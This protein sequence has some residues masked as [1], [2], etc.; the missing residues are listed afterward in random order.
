MGVIWAG[1]EDIQFQNGTPPGVDTTSGRFRAAFS[2]C[3]LSRTSTGGGASKGTQFPGGAV[4]TA[5]VTWYVS[6]AGFDTAN[7]N[8]ASIG[9][10]GQFSSSKG[11]VLGNAANG[12]LQLALYKYDGTTY[13]KLATESGAS[14]NF[15]GR[16]DMLILNYGATATVTVY[17]NQSPIPVITFTG[18]VTVSGM[19]NFDCFIWGPNLA[20]SGTSSTISEVIV[21]T[22]DTRAYLGLQ[23]LA[24]TG[25]GTTHT[26]TNNTFSNINGTAF[27]DLNPASD[28]NNG[29]IQEYTITPPI[30]PGSFSYVAIIQAAR[31]AKSA[32]PAA[33]GYNDVT[34]GGG[35]GFGT[36]A[37]KAPTI[38]YGCYEQI[39]AVNP[40]T[41]VAFVQGSMT[42]MQLAAKAIT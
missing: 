21:S 1:W 2:R 23:T 33:L 19:T 27:S 32:A 3:G 42:A 22:D 9:G 7:V 20:G 38:S 40:L 12:S 24:L 30:S 15:T 6:E 35:V 37:T 10:V 4:T 14:L 13:T 5:N 18:D 28:N 8:P 25:A 39:D 17:L 36:G 41:G 11:L 29:D 16:I 34:G 26:W 31:M